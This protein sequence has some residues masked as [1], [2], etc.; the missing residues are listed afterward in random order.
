[1]DFR[2]THP[3]TTRPNYRKADYPLINDIIC[4]ID[5]TYEF[6]DGDVDAQLATLENFLNQIIINFIPTITKGA[7]SRPVWSDKSCSTFVNQKKKAHNRLRKHP[8][9]ANLAAFKA[10]RN[11]AV[12]GIRQARNRYESNLVLKAKTNPKLLFSYINRNKKTIA[13]NCLKTS[14]GTVLLE[15]ADIASEFSNFFASTL[16][17]TALP[18]PPPPTFYSGEIGFHVGEVE[19]ELAALKEDSSAGP[20]GISPLFLKNCASCIALPLFLI[21]ETSVRTCTF[22]AHWKD[23]NLTPIHKEGSNHTV[24][25]YRPI[26]LLSVASKIL[27]RFV[28]RKLMDTCLELNILPDSQHG[29]VAGRSRL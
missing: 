21:F 13:T 7:S 23:A 15:D 6:E 19:A 25:N 22:P 4:S 2:I 10:A 1:M 14:T 26:S 12:S 28:F 29:F 27:E 24:E 18:S 8:T 9:P 5:W 16:R 17:P 3:I 20:D 11:A